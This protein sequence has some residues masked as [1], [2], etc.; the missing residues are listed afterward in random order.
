MS[1]VHLKEKKKEK[2]MWSLWLENR[3]F[4]FEVIAIFFWRRIADS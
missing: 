1:D 2:E 3:F 4:L